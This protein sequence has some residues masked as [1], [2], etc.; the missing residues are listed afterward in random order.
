MLPEGVT[1]AAQVGMVAAAVP[2]ARALVAQAG[3]RGTAVRVLGVV[4]AAPEELVVLGVHPGMAQV[5]RAV[6]E[7][8]Q[9]LV[10]RVAPEAMVEQEVPRPQDKG[11]VA[12]PV[13]TAAEEIQEPLVEM[14]ATAAQ[15][16]PPAREQAVTVGMVVQAE[17]VQTGELE[18][19]A[20]TAALV[21]PDRALA[22]TV[23]TAR[24]MGVRVDQGAAG[25]RPATPARMT[26]IAQR[27]AHTQQRDE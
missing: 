14:A 20:E 11:A 17:L 5:V 4:L 16:V 1:T 21:V 10:N 22:A 3:A 27:S 18:G 24:M 12:V 19:L 9:E 25:T 13:V 6:L 8:T 2:Q 7:G 26:D 15:A 23:A